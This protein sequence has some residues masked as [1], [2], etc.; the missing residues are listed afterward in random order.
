M[1]SDRYFISGNRL[2]HKVEREDDKLFHV[3][4]APSVFSKY[5]LHQVNDA[6]GHNGTA[7]TY[8]I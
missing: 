6:L 4:V 5:I 3:L 1:A 7:K 2:L 8:Y